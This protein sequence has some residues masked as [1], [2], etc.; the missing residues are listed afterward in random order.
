MGTK[1][2]ECNEACQT[3]IGDEYESSNIYSQEELKGFSGNIN[4]NY[5]T[6]THLSATINKLWTSLSQTQ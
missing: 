1:T 2:A 6:Y 5:S 3:L 4:L